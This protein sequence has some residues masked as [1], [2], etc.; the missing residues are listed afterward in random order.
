MELSSKL[1]AQLKWMQLRLDPDSGAILF[2]PHPAL[3][4]HPAPKREGTPAGRARQGQ[5]IS[6]GAPIASALAAARLVL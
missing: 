5:A 3:L 2:C 6:H 4:G 1:S